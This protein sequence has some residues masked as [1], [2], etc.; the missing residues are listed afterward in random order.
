MTTT[1]GAIARLRQKYSDTVGISERAIDEAVHS[2]TNSA[3][4]YSIDPNL[5]AQDAA[6]YK[7]IQAPTI[8]TDPINVRRNMEQRAALQRQVRTALQAAQKCVRLPADGPPQAV[9]G[10]PWQVWRDMYEDLCRWDQLPHPPL[11]RLH[12]VL[13]RDGRYWY[14]LLLVLAIV[15]LALAV[16]ALA[17]IKHRR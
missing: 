16:R 17:R 3:L 10:G 13:T 6:R 14:V 2:N 12:M 11:R 9:G 7:D 1:P 15:G 4:I 8:D 5:R